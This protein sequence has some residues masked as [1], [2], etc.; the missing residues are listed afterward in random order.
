M[1]YGSL[2]V[3]R[4]KISASQPVFVLPFEEDGADELTFQ[5]MELTW[6]SVELL[7][8][9]PLTQLKSAR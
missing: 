5:A 1:I 4:T 3:L 7:G 6:K 9:L 2:F 8:D